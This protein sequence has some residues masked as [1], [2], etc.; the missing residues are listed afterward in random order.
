VILQYIWDIMK[1]ESNFNVFNIL[2]WPLFLCGTIMTSCATCT[3]EHHNILRFL[4][5]GGLAT[6]LPV[7]G[8]GVE[9]QHNVLYMIYFRRK[10]QSTNKNR[11]HL[12]NWNNNFEITFVAFPLK[13]LRKKYRVSKITLACQECW[14]VFWDFMPN[15]VVLASKWCKN[16]SN[17][18]FLSAVIAI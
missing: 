9:V 11:E 4:F 7:G 17:T 14:D 6:N 3:M 5:V 2:C 1:G 8:L 10:E 12:M 15:G 18:E 13:V 16:C